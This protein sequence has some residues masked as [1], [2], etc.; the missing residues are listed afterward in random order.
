MNL[1]PEQIAK[2]AGRATTTAAAYG[3]INTSHPGQNM[4]LTLKDVKTLVDNAPKVVG[5][6]F[7]TAAGTSTPNIQLPATAKYIV[8]FVFGGVPTNTDTFSLLINNERAI[9]NASVTPYQSLAGKPLPGF[10]EFFRPV[11]GATSVN[12]S[13]VSIAGGDQVTF[14]IVYV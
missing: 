14:Q 4:G 9:D 5:T 10:Y 11:A 8:G 7:T 2:L 1:T 13:Y 6:T 12:L 3:H